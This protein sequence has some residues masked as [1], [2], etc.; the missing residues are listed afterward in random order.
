MYVCPLSHVLLDLSRLLLG[1][2]TGETHFVQRQLILPGSA[3]HDGCQ[4]GLRIEELKKS[5]CMDTLDELFDEKKTELI[6]DFLEVDANG[7]SIVTKKEA[8]DAFWH[9]FSFLKL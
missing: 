6:D 8:I 3:L 1:H 2:L 7:D 4:E 9:F 5:A